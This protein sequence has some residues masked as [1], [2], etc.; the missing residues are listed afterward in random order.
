MAKLHDRRRYRNKPLR[1]SAEKYAPASM[2]TWKAGRTTEAHRDLP[3]I[4]LS[5]CHGNA[6]MTARYDI[7]RWAAR[8][9]LSPATSSWKGV[10]QATHAYPLQP[11]EGLEDGGFEIEIILEE[12][13]SV[14]ALPIEDAQDLDFFDRP[15]LSPEEIAEGTVRPENIIGSYGVYPKTKTNHRVGNTRYATGKPCHI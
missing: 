4:T 2:G 14:C 8:A 10:T 5:K 9:P 3:V 13:P 1:R 15:K 12:A 6:G 11:R 7:K